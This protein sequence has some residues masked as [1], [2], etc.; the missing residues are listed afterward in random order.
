MAISST[1]IGSGLDVE[2]II[3]QLMAVEKKPLAM[4]QTKAG[5]ID[6]QISAFGTIK[7]QLSALS[8]AV[9]KLA[10][11]STWNAKTAASSNAQMVGASVTDG[12]AAAASSFTVEVSQLARTQAVSSNAVTAGAGFGAGK[13]SIQLGDWNDTETGA[14]SFVAGDK[15]AVEVTVDAGDTLATIAAKINKAGAGVSA[16]V[17]KDLSGERLMLRSSTTGEAA[18]FRVGVNTAGGAGNDLGLLAFDAAQP[19]QGMAANPIQY[20][21]NALA[22]L[23][24]VAIRSATNVLTDTVPGLSITL[25]QKTTAPVDITVSADTSGL[26]GTIQ[27]F[28]TAYNA[29]NQTL[30][31]ATAYNATTKTAALLQGDSTAVGLQNALRSLVG[32]PSGGGSLQRLTQLGITVAKDGAGNLAV[33]TAKLDEALKDP[34]KVQQFFAAPENAGDPGATGFATRLSAFTRAAV[35]SD[36][37]LATRDESL[38]TQRKDNL[39]RQGEMSDRLSLT[40]KRLRAQYTALDTKMGSLNALDA[41]VK[42][43]VAQWNKPSR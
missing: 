9:T 28:V 17:I 13:L 3:S 42:Q 40:E 39:K 7:S 38:R 36:G 30:N 8:D 15:A 41:Y 33:D 4:L 2:L 18:G 1:G 6:S 22:T 19:G 43:Q 31:S 26:R 34:A 21:R 27:A 12:G 11:A 16:T 35:G 24:G 23:N 29:L 20:A 25:S 37:V 10:A 14:T 5:T 32:A